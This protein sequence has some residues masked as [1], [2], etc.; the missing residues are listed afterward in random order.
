MSNAL[1]SSL[2]HVLERR[3]ARGGRHVDASEL[4]ASAIVFAPHPDDECLGC[5]GMILR[6]IAAGA[7]VGVVF[8][9]D[10]A[11]S[12]AR[13]LAPTRLRKLRMLEGRAAAARLGLRADH[14][15]FLGFPD[16]ALSRSRSRLTAEVATLLDGRPPKQVFVPHAGEL[17]ADHRTVRAIVLDALSIGHH[18]LQV[19]EY[20]VWWWFHWPWVRL[21]L[22][23]TALTRD[24]WQGTVR[25]A[26][27][28]R[29]ARVFNRWL[30]LNGLC[31]RKQAALAA[32]ATQMT[33]L[34]DS[35][36][37]PVL[38]DVADGDFLAR[39]LKDREFFAAYRIEDGRRING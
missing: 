9:S 36:Q 37:W 28:L 3:L 13:L 24:L 23:P 22:R 32:H 2:Q 26:F 20:P 1:R 34:G 39:L 14:V 30:H 15:R 11:A 7:E 19:F 8:V 35:P 6:K 25:N 21:S 17:P 33:R 12:H 29:T 38:A 31:E 27:G 18:S 5:G 10:G 16:G 4:A